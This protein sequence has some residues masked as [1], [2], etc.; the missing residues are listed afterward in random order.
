MSAGHEEVAA[1]LQEGRARWACH[2]TYARNLPDVA[3]SGGLLSPQL[4]HA[5]PTHSWGV[6]E[7]VG[8]RLI[9]LSLAVS[10]AM[11]KHRMNGSEIAVLTVDLLRIPDLTRIRVSPH[12][13][14]GHDATRF[15]TGD[16]D[17]AE[18]IATI[19]ASDRRHLAE[20]LV[21][22]G[23]PLTAI[24][25]V[26]FG[27][28]QARDAW[29]PA[30]VAALSDDV[31]APEVRLASDG[32]WFRLPDDFT[33]KARTSPTAVGVDRLVGQVPPGWGRVMQQFDEE[34][35]ELEEPHWMDEDDWDEP[36]EDEG[37]ASWAD[38]YDDGEPDDPEWYQPSIRD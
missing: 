22:D 29:W 20:I 8:K 16:A 18:S 14:A 28:S 19:N 5:P 25:G 31:V 4:R 33:V 38:F 30:F 7:A 27:D 32:R 13:S 36:E 2:L 26:V 9:C 24:Y 6:N 23:V 11:I 15:L 3:A 34:E 35:P 1:A 37:P 10:W 21:P 17:V 12:N